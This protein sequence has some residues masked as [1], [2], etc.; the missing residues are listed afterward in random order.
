MKKDIQDTFWSCIK[1]KR[2]GKTPS[3]KNLTEMFSQVA[4]V[5]ILKTYRDATLG[6]L[7]VEPKAVETARKIAK[8]N[9]YIMSPKLTMKPGVPD[10]MFPNR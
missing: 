7:K 4:G 2:P 6:T 3:D 10:H 9:G 1:D 8:E 5:V